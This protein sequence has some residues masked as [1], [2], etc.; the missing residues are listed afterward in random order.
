MGNQRTTNNFTSTESA[1][2]SFTSTP[3][4]I[5][6]M[7]GCM[8]QAVFSGGTPNGTLTVELSAD[9]DTPSNWVTVSEPEDSSVTVAGVPSEPIVYEVYSN[10]YWVRLRYVRSSGTS[11]VAIT[12][13]GKGGV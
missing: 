5:K 8:I 4:L 7:S 12:Y 10:A 2:A 9:D 11:D 3:Y 6:N 1:G 13:N